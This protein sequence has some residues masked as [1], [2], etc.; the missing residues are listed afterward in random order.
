VAAFAAAAVQPA[1]I[2]RLL[3]DAEL[4]KDA[5]CEV[6]RGDSEPAAKRRA[7]DMLTETLSLSERWRARPLG[8]P[9]PSTA[10]YPWGRPLSC[11]RD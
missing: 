5:P 2:E 1:A 8:G 4:E 11:R 10:A 6:A 7:E 9:L 3:A